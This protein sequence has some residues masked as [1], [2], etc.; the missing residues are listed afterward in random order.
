VV[1]HGEA[2]QLANGFF[3]ASEFALARLRPTQV[4]QL[5][6]ERRR[7]LRIAP[8]MRVFYLR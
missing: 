8:V 2:E 4:A 7:G 6:A 3:V 1:I 5:E